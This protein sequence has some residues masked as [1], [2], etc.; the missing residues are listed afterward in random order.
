MSTEKKKVLVMADWYAPGYK[1][2]GPI[3]S[4]VNFAE[5]LKG[6][7][8]IYVFTSDRDLNEPFPYK[9]I[10][11]N[12]WVEKAAGIKVF[13]ASPD[14]LSLTGIRKL[15]SEVQPQIVYL[16]SM[17]SRYFSLYPLLWKRISLAETRFVLAPRGMLKD[18]AIQFKRRKKKFFLNLFRWAGLHKK[19]DFHCTDDTELQDVKKYFGSVT[20]KVL[21]NLPGTQKKLVLPQS[22]LPGALK[23]LFVGRIHPIKNLHY[24][25]LRLMQVRSKIELS[26]VATIEDAGYWKD[27]RKIIDGLPGNVKVELKGEKP[28]YEIEQLMIENHVF[29]LPTSGENFGHAIFE[30]LA[31]GRPVLISDQTP[32]RNLAGAKAG[33]D[34]SLSE[35]DKFVEIIE[36]FASMNES[37]L[38]EWCIGAWQFAHEYLKYSDKRKQYLEF[39][40]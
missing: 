32:W 31:A 27:C 6:D 12:E 19:I 18:S 4:C 20:A 16:N 33:W 5:H 40:R 30:A 15:I 25:L 26:I 11:Q 29:V 2:G 3:R 36:A 37:E 10:V 28:H 13:Y 9:D 39:F 8:D 1:A 22:K 38:N 23:L 21:G 35:Q 14:W 34:I 17:F 24:L 7:L